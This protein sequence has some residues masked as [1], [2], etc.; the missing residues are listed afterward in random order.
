MQ[1]SISRRSFLGRV[2]A[3]G[4]VAGTVVAGPATMPANAQD[5]GPWL[6]DE[7]WL[8][9]EAVG[10]T[11]VLRS[12]GNP[13]PRHVIR[14]L[15]GWIVLPTG[16]DDHDNLEWALR[17]TA[18]GGTVRLVRGTYKVGMPIIVADFNGALVGA[19][20]ARTTITCTDEFSYEIWEA[21]N[22]G[23][24]RGEPKP[25]PFPRIPV[26]GSTTRGAPALIGFYKTPLQTGEDPAARANRI[27]IRNLRCRGAMNG[28]LWAFGDEVLCFNIIN[29][30]DWNNPENAPATTRQ[31][32]LVSGVEVDG[33][34]SPAFGPFENGCACI[35][36]LGGI[37]LTSN[38]NLE[39]DVDGD[40]LG[41]VNGGLVGV[42]PAEGNVTFRSC[43][44]RNCRVGPGVVGY[45]DGLLTFENITTDGCRGN[46]LQVL[47][48]SRCRVLLRGNDLRCDSFILPPALAGGAV[49]MPSSLGCL[50]AVQGLPAALGITSNVQWLAL[51][52]DAEAH[53]RHPEAGPLGTWRPQ[54][55]V[56]APEPSVFRITDNNCESSVTPNT[57]CIHVADVAKLAYGLQTCRVLIE[58]NGCEGSETCIGL[59]HMD[60]AHVRFNDCSSQAYGVE[61][62]NSPAANV[63]YN[64]FD[65]PAGVAGCE[66][67][68]LELGEKID[69]SR[70]VPG[71]GMC[72]PQG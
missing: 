31:D 7:K 52:N 42:T 24:S 66:I 13:D 70:V 23:K 37:V 59:E 28:E 65:F 50:A 26:A 67:R 63:A 55:P 53:A 4:A 62:Y 35:T 57:Y 10:P 69:F 60:Y 44:F 33:Y 22:G 30:I 8:D 32:V 47:D 40:A 72:M 51:A 29:S 19:G 25:P 16:S 27:E 48:V 14:Q 41:I 43:T 3:A 58:G 1:N 6:D 20:A 34:R 12:F 17:H 38:Y 56:A 64:R 68:V 49:D 45:R 15:R 21:P 54:G 2:G 18:P 11:D 5:G 46:C 36:V 61:L 39:G 71:A 9:P